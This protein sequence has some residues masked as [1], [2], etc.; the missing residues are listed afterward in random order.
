MQIAGVPERRVRLKWFDDAGGR[1]VDFRID[2]DGQGIGSDMNGAEG[3]QAEM[4]ELYSP[5]AGAA[6]KKETGTSPAIVMEKSDTATAE[7]V[8]EV[9]VTTIPAYQSTFCIPVIM[10]ANI[11]VGTHCVLY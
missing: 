8:D 5:D 7:L 11:V 6:N 10:I 4:A 9:T 2:N 1:R 3:Q